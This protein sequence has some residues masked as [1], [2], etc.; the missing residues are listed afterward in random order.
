MQELTATCALLEAAGS[1]L[2]L[3]DDTDDEWDDADTEVWTDDEDTPMTDAE[4]AGD[5]A[6]PRAPAT[7]LRARQ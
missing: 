3:H 6:P 2:P 7:P 5:D 1:V 4:E